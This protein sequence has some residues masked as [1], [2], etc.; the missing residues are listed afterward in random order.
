MTEVPD[1]SRQLERLL[2]QAADGVNGVSDELISCAEHRLYAL[3]RRMLKG[4]P[5]LRRWEQT[6]D[7][8]QTAALRLHRSLEN[9]Q[10][11]TVGEFMGLAATQVRRTL[12]DLVRHHFGPEGKHAQ[13]QSD[14]DGIAIIAQLDDQSARRQ[15][16]SEPETLEQWLRFHE[17]VELL[18]E[19]ERQVFEA[20]WYSNL[21]QQ[22]VGDLLGI[23]IS[24]VKRRMRSV[25]IRL[26]T[27][28]ED[29]HPDETTSI[30][31]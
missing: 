5:R 19:D 24:T 20:I 4:Y 6:D 7:V 29:G 3:A 22:Q 11:E 2:L 13:H 18:P 10:P 12:I 30:A 31:Q 17:S 27:V 23:S 26:A 21:S 1:E 16:A 9:V 14:A 25:R 28:L 8:F 15:S